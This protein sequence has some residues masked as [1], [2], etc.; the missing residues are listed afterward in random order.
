MRQKTSPSG[1]TVRDLFAYCAVAAVCVKLWAPNELPEPIISGGPDVL[2]AVRDGFPQQ[3]THLL[4]EIPSTRVAVGE[5][6]H[7]DLRQLEFMARPEVVAGLKEAGFNQ[8]VI[9][10]HPTLQPYYDQM[11]RGKN[12]EMP[13]FL[14]SPSCDHAVFRQ[15]WALRRTLVWNANLQGIKV[16][17]GDV[18][19][20]KYD[21]ILNQAD[22]SNLKIRWLLFAQI[23]HASRSS[24]DA[25]VSTFVMEKEGAGGRT[26]IIRGDGHIRADEPESLRHTWP[27]SVMFSFAYYDRDK[28]RYREQQEALCRN[29]GRQLDIDPERWSKSQIE[30]LQQLNT[31]K[32]NI[33]WVSY[34][35]SPHYVINPFGPQGMFAARSITACQPAIAAGMPRVP[36]VMLSQ[37]TQKGPS[38]GS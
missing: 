25:E 15:T 2:A 14:A 10:S 3:L 5:T 12:P 16:I 32:P 19:N 36:P 18:N 4:K 9:E 38:L 21:D 6:S 22:Q 29:G 7:C 1:I 13:D 20:G 31:E 26:L 28:S 37:G 17:A 27:G 11:A 34:A 30:R 35:A 8:I 23:F 24:D 33:K